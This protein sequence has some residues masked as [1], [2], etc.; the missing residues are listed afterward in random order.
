MEQN[1]VIEIQNL[2]KRYGSNKAVNNI[3]FEVKHGE[4]LGFLGPNGAGKTTTMN[5]LTGYIS[6]NEGSVKVC[7]FNILEQPNQVKSKIGYLPEQPPLYY[8]MTVEE[9]LNFVY[10]LKKVKLPRK[11]H[12]D[13]IMKTVGVEQMRGRLI[14]NLSKGYKQRTGLAQALVGDPEV[15][16]LDEPTVG[17][18]PR[19]IIEI[20]NVI[21]NLGK[22]RTIIL[23]THILQEVSAICDRVVII[24]RGKIAAMDTIENLSGVTSS[25]GR[26]L[27]RL[28]ADEYKVKNAL[29][30][31]ATIKYSEI[32]GVKEKNTV[33]VIVESSVEEDIRIQLFQT[34]AD[35]QIPILIFRPME[36]TLEE[37]FIKVTGSAEAEAEAEPPQD[38]PKNFTEEVK[39]KFA[40][41]PEDEAGEEEE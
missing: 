32:L 22:K 15:L 40:K 25:S 4:I 17:L 29:A 3:S 35:R 7:G 12:L 9:Y 24:N 13:E 34:F 20:R 18:D 2:T 14:K 19:Q 16:V 21:K 31:M 39:S 11:K 37:I 28:A 8:D 41:K 38:A 30:D 23:S 1:N 10:D 27:L 5:I 36:L 6:S 26:Y 33:D